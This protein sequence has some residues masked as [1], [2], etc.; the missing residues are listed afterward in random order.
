MID[1]APM[2]VLGKI[3]VRKDPRNGADVIDR[4]LAFAASRSSSLATM[5]KTSYIAT[6]FLVL[7]SL[8]LVSFSSDTSL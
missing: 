6:F 8:T 2:Y 5:R 3:P 1:P 4:F 7:I